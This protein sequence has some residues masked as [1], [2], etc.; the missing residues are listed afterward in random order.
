MSVANAALI[1]IYKVIYIGCN[2]GTQSPKK[3][4]TMGFVGCNTGMRGALAAILERKVTIL[5]RKSLFCCN[6]GT[7][8]CNTR[9]LICKAGTQG[10]NTG[11]QRLKWPFN[12]F[13][14][15]V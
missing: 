15:L 4:V 2:T 9:T 13:A 10:C 3:K 6:T 7:Q 8:G 14:K 11:T 5:E 12:L 1:D